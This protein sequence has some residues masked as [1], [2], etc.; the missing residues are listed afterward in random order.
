MRLKKW[1]KITLGIIAFIA[2]MIM[3]SDCENTTIF[4]ISHLIASGIF[5]LNVT[6]LIKY[7]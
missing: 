1:V 7:N 2:F 5:A 4:I 6:L 3:A